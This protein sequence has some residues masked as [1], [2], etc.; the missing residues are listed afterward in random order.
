MSSLSAPS[1]LFCCALLLAAQAAAD[2]PP[3]LIGGDVAPYSWSE[4]GRA[5]GPATDLVREIAARLGYGAPDIAIYPW[6]RTTTVGETQPQ[7]LIFPLSRIA[8]R[9]QRYTWIVE[10]LRDQYVLVVRAGYSGDITSLATLAPARIGYL[11]GSPGEQLL[12]DAGRVAQ[13]E[14]VGSEELNA[15]KLRAGRIDVWIANRKLAE[16]AWI[17]TGGALS[18]LR[19]GPAILELH[20]YLAAARQFPPAEVARWRK[21][22]DTMRM[23]GACQAILNRYDAGPCP[24]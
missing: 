1:R 9:E 12:T 19:Y 17:R 20:M 15:R 13:G 14:A 8:S 16:Q 7:T 21:A 24:D 2:T 11:R 18:E 10:L 4:K 23:D 3:L 22:Y 6:A 5:I